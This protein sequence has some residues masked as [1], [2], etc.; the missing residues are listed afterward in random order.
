MALSVY[1]GPYAD[2]THKV[3]GAA[4]EVHRELGPGLLES[5]YEACLVH[6][7]GL[8]GLSSLRQRDVPVIYKGVRIDVGFRLD[9][10]VEGQVLVELKAIEK[11][12]PVHEAQL[13]TY[14]KLTNAKVGLILNFNTKLLADGVTRR[15]L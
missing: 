1:D 12:L 11:V 3:I 14:M 6:E 15:V 7:L 2:L 10:L 9:V 13:L 4:I 8:A 5:V